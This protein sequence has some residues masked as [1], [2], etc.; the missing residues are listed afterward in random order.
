MG[1]I[2][3]CNRNR[4]SALQMRIAC[5]RNPE[6]LYP[7]GFRLSLF[8]TPT[9]EIRLVQDSAFAPTPSRNGP[10][11]LRLTSEPAPGV[12][13]RVHHRRVRPSDGW[14]ANIARENETTA[15]RWALLP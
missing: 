1:M 4:S 2:P 14:D 8:R 9:L 12:M 11:L 5:I 13:H 3:I 6:R 15:E 10:R 7:A